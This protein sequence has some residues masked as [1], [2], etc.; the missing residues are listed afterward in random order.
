[1]PSGPSSV[2]RATGRVPL[3]SSARPAQPSSEVAPTAALLTDLYELTMAAAY[4]AEGLSEREATFSLFV[5]D[6]PPTRGY[7]VAAGLDSA[8]GYLRAL[9]FT[10][11]DLEFLKGQIGRA[12]CRESV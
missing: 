6:L 5:R 12:S 7:L 4:V 9:K 1:M 11:Q 10:D 2:A 8:L 3:R